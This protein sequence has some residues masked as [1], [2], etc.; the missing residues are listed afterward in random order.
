VSRSMSVYLKKELGVPVN[1]R[2]TTGGQGVSGHALG[3]L[4][5]PD[6]YTISMMTLELNML[7]WRG[8]TD[9]TWRDSEPLMSLN[10]DPAAIFVRA[11]STEF[12]TILDV[13]AAVKANPGKLKASGTASLGAWHLALAGWLISI[14]QDPND[15]VWVPSQGSNPSLLELMSGNIDLVCCSVPEAESLIAGGE[16]RCLGVMADKRLD[17]EKFK[18]HPTLKEEGSDWTLTGWRGL[19]VP[20]GTPVEIRKK[21]VAALT[22]IVK[23]ETKVNGESFPEFMDAQGFDRTW[24]SADDFATFLDDNDQELGKILTSDAFKSV[25]G[26]PIGPMLFPTVMFG[27]FVISLIGIAF[28]ARRTKASVNEGTDKAVST[29]PDD[30]DDNIELHWGQFAL[31]VVSVL[32]FI[33]VADFAGFITTAAVILAGFSIAQGAKPTHAILL[34]VVASPLVYVLFSGLL[35]VTLPVGWFG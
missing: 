29:E 4:A 12:K 35:Q 19:G 24:R 6:G 30:N 9:L 11:D 3:L 7:H 15:I 27:V 2:N 28:Q 22:R 26:G 16:V 10:E 32:G 20:K 13:A 33:L 18:M 34:G 23:G 8:L 5:R 25:K 17:A 21:L 1:V 31:V 14:E